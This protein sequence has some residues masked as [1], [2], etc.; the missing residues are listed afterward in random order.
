MEDVFVVPATAGWFVLYPVWSD[1]VVC[2]I[3]REPVIAWRVDV[4]AAANY[5][6]P[7]TADDAVQG[8]RCMLQ[9]PNGRMFVCDECDILDEDDAKQ[10]FEN[11]QRIAQAEMATKAEGE[12]K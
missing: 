9:R 2:E 10:W 6:M 8:R 11:E 5:S 3:N 4:D 1:G 7:V 12:P